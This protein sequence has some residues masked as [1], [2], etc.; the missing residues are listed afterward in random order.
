VDVTAQYFTFDQDEV[1]TARPVMPSMLS[2]DRRVIQQDCLCY[3]MD[4][5]HYEFGE[6]STG[7]DPLPEG[8]RRS[9]RPGDPAPQ[10][11]PA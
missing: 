6:E 10:R 5:I 9:D 3:L 2:L 11:P 4:R 7:I 1:R 8:I